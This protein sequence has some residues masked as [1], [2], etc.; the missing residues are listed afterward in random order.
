MEGEV[1]HQV[2]DALKVK[3]APGERNDFVRR[4]QRTRGPAIS[5]FARGRLSANPTKEPEEQIA[6]LREAVAEDPHYAVAWA[7]LTGA[8]I[9]SPMP[10]A[11]REKF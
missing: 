6:L 1:A 8:Y 3:L 4:P 9:H 10:I 7:E 11:L 2:A 5:Y